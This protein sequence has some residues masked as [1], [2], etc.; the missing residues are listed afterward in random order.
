M[1][2]TPI[3]M[4][5]GFALASYSVVGNDVIQTLGTFLTSNERRVQWWVLW[6]FGASI[7]AFVLING[8]LQQD[9]AYGR[10]DKFTFPETYAWYYLLPPL[11]LL[12]ITR[13]GIPVSTTFMILTLFSLSD[14]P[15]D[16]GSMVSSIFDTDQKL[17]S[18]IQK[19]LMGYLIAFG[20]GMLIYLAITRLTEKY[21]I[22]NPIS[23]RGQIIWTVL[24]WFSTGFL[25]FQW[26]TQDLANIYIYLRGGEALSPLTFAIS[27]I[28]LLGFLAYIFYNKGGAVQDVVRQKTNTADIRS[29]TFID[30]IYG[31]IL[32]V[33]KDDYF[34]LW[35]AKI[36]M[37]TTW[38]F[39]GLLAGREIAVRINLERKVSRSV[40]GMVLRDLGKIFLGLVI[41]V[42]LV[43]IIKLLAG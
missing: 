36:P 1:D 34:G 33:F 37:S 28:I 19:S 39:I 32:Y 35:G 17:G 27:L 43:F 24:Q 10:L 5:L 29:A 30:F 3:V 14:I 21:F 18:M 9:I 4:W 7:L 26:L 16:L 42:V 2:I 15:N 40:L 20:S 13:F 38:V 41:S 11:V 12:T 31:I 22:D 23:S 6:L 8:Y 25:W